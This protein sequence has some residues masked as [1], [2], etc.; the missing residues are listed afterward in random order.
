MQPRRM[1]LHN[2]QHRQGGKPNEGLLY[3]RASDSPV[4]EYER[5]AELLDAREVGR[6]AGHQFQAVLQG[7]GGDH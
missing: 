1:E 5:I 3:R 6:V 2:A 7:D 4:G